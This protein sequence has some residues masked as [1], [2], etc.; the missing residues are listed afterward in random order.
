MVQSLTMTEQTF[1]AGDPV[2]DL[3]AESAAPAL[4]TELPGPLAAALIARDEAVTSPSL[5]RL[6]PLVARRARGLVIEDVDGNRFLDFNAGI[7][8]V[9][10]G[11]AHPDVNAAIHRQVDDILHYCSSDFYLPAYAELSERLAALAPMRGAPGSVRTFLSNSGTEAVE[12]ALKLARHHTGRPNVI[13]FLGAFHGRSLGSLS[14]TASKARQRA[15]FGIVTPG[16][17][18][19]PYWDPYGGTGLTGAAYIEQVLF[20]KLTHP[21]DVAAVFVEPVQG[22][23]GYIVPPAGWLADLRDLCDRH[24]IL[25]VMDE[26]QTGVGRT[27]TMWACQHDGVEPDVMCIGKGLASGLPLAGI[28]ARSEI[29]DWEPGGHGSTFGG[30]PV[31]CAAALATLDLV[32]AELADNA[33]K[34]GAHLLSAVAELQ[35]SRP[36]LTQG[37]G[38][39]LMIGLDLPDHDRAVALE[40]A[41]FRRGLLVLTCGERSVRLAPPL[42]V[43]VEQADTAVGILG[44]A[45]AELA[46]AEGGR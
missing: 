26:V 18:H 41:C 6:Y 34:V 20:S 45:L 27:G 40:Q 15:G 19:A 9:A 37:R 4:R 29:M 23:G 5:T 28:V 36:L 12:A 7:A 31:A 22:E 44:D 24:G 8:V 25:L 11:H 43:T 38:R 2:D 1:R 39:G 16:A 10:A 17:F 13:A 30:N 46:A 21:S 3:S 42:V 33:A 35:A 32:E 14:L